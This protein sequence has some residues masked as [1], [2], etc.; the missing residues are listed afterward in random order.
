MDRERGVTNMN[1]NEELWKYSVRTDL[2]LEA[3]EMVSEDTEREVPGVKV[4]VEEDKEWEIVVT[5]VEIFSDEGSEIMHKP[6]GNYITIECQSMKENDIDA[7]EEIIMAA[8]E[9]LKKLMEVDKDSKVLVVGL[10]NR[11]VTP[12]ALGP[13]VIAKLLVTRHLHDYLPEE[14]NDAV[15]SVSALAPGVMGQTG[16]ETMEIITGLVEH[17]KPDVVICI[18][19]LASRKTSRVNT[20]I[21]ISDTGVHP[22]AGVGNK[23][24]GLNE[25]TLGVPVIAIGIPTVVDAATLV[26]DTIDYLTKAIKEQSPNSPLLFNGLAD[27]NEQEKYMLIKEVL[28]PYVGE[29]YVTPKDVDAVIDRIS[30][31]V[32]NSLNLMLHEGLERDDI[33]RFLY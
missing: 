3:R 31:I 9:Q 13:K 24:A 33:N 28:T 30:G 5:W 20:T 10:G 7:H 19:A 2:A 16:V 12:D 8:T 11:E 32:S 1:V 23:R 26:N 17:V 22:G 4:T 14:I 21:Q 6:K 29:L 18:D 27:F 15:S 25:E